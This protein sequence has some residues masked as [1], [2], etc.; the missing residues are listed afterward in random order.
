MTKLILCLPIN[1]V[2]LCILLATQYLNF[3]S[4]EALKIAIFN[5]Y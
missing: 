1:N 5:Q 3:N 2:K 4:E